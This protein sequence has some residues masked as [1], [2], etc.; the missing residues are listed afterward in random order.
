MKIA[1]VSEDV[2]PDRQS[3]GIAAYT[4]AL[5]AS[6]ARRG[7]QITVIGSAGPT[8]HHERHESKLDNAAADFA[9]TVSALCVKG[10][11]PPPT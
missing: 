6:L 1:L 3:G 2:F 10:I 11:E 5:A 4:N 9:H 7:H 8:Q